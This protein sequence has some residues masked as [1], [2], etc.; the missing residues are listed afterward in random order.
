MLREAADAGGGASPV[1][2]PG[3]RGVL[4][5]WPSGTRIAAPCLVLMIAP[6]IL[7]GGSPLAAVG[8]FL[9]Y[10]G[11]VLLPGLALT[12]LLVREEDELL[13]AAMGLLLGTVSIGLF[14]FFCRATGLFAG[15]YAWPI[16]TL[17][18][19]TLAC[20]RTSAV[21]AP[22][23]RGF[24]LLAAVLPLVFL[25]VRTG[26]LLLKDLLF[27]AGNAAE[28]LK[29]G[30]LIDPRVAGR[31]LNYH[32]LSHA[33][34]AA[35]TVVTGET[36]ADVFRFWF[37]GFYPLVLV[38][39]VFGLVRELAQSAVAALVAVLVLVL[40]YDVGLGL[41]GNRN[42]DWGFLSRLDLGIFLSPTTCLG[43]ALLAGMARALL[44]WFEPGRC[45]GWRHGVELALLA[46]GASLAKGSVMPIV[47]AGAGFACVVESVRARRWSRRWFAAA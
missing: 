14:V 23:V 29:E 38:M 17:V 13:S 1:S 35:A 16:S 28:L 20:R 12:A 25:R 24:A 44:R 47:I 3:R 34:A 6:G 8:V 9:F 39:L 31:P 26:Y 5:D 21:V 18:F 41:M 32:L 15:L 11:W 4:A 27:H 46:L 19:W 37:L 40:H 42:Q 10:L 30:A 2:T 33:L 45:V 43:L 36:I 22:S 7:A